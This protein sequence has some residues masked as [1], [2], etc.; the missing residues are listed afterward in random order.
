M[1]GRLSYN[2]I[3][4]TYFQKGKK[5]IVEGHGLG[6]QG[7]RKSLLAVKLHSK[8]DDKISILTL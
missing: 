3:T 5:G 6:G 8:M 1:G 2:I 7:T 4:I